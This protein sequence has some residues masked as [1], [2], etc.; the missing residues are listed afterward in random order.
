[1]LNLLQPCEVT[2]ILG[3]SSDWNGWSVVL[4]WW[5]SCYENLSD[6]IGSFASTPPYASCIVSPHWLIPLEPILVRLLQ[7]MDARDVIWALDY[8]PQQIMRKAF[9]YMKFKTK[10][11]DWNKHTKNYNMMYTFD[12]R[13]RLDFSYGRWNKNRIVSDSSLSKDRFVMVSQNK[14]LFS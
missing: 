10:P 3:S 6:L 9:R 2:Y 11:S 8:T 5:M 14:P 1:M 12:I 4:D 7:A 13:G